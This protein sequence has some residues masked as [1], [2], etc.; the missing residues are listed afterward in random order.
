MS[1]AGLTDTDRKLLRAK[2][3]NASDI[4]SIKITSNKKKSRVVD[5]S[6]ATIRLKYYEVYYKILFMHQ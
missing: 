5:V 6:T 2:D 1:F 3:A 4:R